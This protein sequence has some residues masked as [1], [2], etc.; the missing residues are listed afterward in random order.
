MHTKW[1]IG[2]VLLVAVLLPHAAQAERLHTTLSTEIAFFEAVASADTLNIPFAG[3]L[4][5]PPDSVGVTTH[6]DKGNQ[7]FADPM[8]LIIWSQGGIAERPASR[9]SSTTRKGRTCCCPTTPPILIGSRPR[10]FATRRQART[11][12]ITGRPSI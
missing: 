11:E 7:S 10:S 5:I 1:S 2:V 6:Y 9:C 4:P 8:E 3:L 12:A